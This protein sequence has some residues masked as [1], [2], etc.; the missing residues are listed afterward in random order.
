MIKIILSPQYK[1]SL[2]RIPRHIAKKLDKK[3]RIFQGNPFDFSLKTHKLTGKLKNYH[4]FSVTYS[5]RVV[6]EF[7][8]ENKV[9]FINIGTHGIY[10]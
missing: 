2:K 3:V 1:K 5:Y 10:K 4:S 7:L 9:L 6:F 8:D